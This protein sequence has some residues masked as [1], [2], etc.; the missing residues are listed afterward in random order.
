MCLESISNRNIHKK[1]VIKI[2]YIFEMNKCSNQLKKG[3]LEISLVNERNNLKDFL[4]HHN[5]E[6]HNED[7]VQ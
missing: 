1:F 2:T 5:D 6:F 3:K 4:I 7:E